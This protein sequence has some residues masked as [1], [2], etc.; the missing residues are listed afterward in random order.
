MRREKEDNQNNIWLWAILMIVL[1]CIVYSVGMYLTNTLFTKPEN[2]GNSS[3]VVSALFSAL[4]FAGI[5]ITILLQRKELDLQKEELKL[6]RKELTA[7]KEEFKTQNETLSHQRFDNTFFQMVSLHH[8]IVNEID[9]VEKYSKTSYKNSG[10]N[11]FMSQSERTTEDAERIHKGRDVFKFCYTRMAYELKEVY[12][13]SIMNQIY[14]KNYQYFQNSFGH[15]FRNLYR[16]IKFVDQSNFTKDEKYSYNS[17]IRAQLSDYE[18]LLLYYNCLTENGFEKFKPL[19]ERY[20]IFKNLPLD[21][22]ATLEHKPF[23]EESAFLKL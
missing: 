20:T 23:Y 5:F 19:I 15:Y 9:H 18:L 22:L 8:N 17:I 1:V 21:K 14:I 4:A 6:T 7:Q 2:I 11:V 3:G 16:I 13:I 10:K 12:D